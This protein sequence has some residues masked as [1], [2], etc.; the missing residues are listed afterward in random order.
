[1]ITSQ[2]KGSTNQ[3]KTLTVGDSIV[4][5]IEGWRLNKRM[6]FSVAESQSL[7][8]QQKA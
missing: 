7:V 1:M 4:K 6:K 8:Q 2:N 3:K 5:N